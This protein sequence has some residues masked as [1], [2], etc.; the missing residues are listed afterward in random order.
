MRVAW[1]SRV[2]S[3]AGRVRVSVPP[4][5]VR[6]ESRSYVRVTSAAQVTSAVAS[7]HQM[8]IGSDSDGSRLTTSFAPRGF[9]LA[10]IFEAPRVLTEEHTVEMIARLEE[11]GWPPWITSGG[12]AERAVACTHCELRLAPTWVRNGVCLGCEHKVRQWERAVTS[13]VTWTSHLPLRHP[14][15]A[16]RCADRG[17]PVT[18]IVASRATSTVASTV[19]STPHIVLLHLPSHIYGASATTSTDASPLHRPLRPGAPV[20]EMPVWTQV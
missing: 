8:F 20:G 4:L 18:S 10:R 12:S 7:V 13:T 6:S 19:I 17:V 11:R 2:G 3:R 16:S 9:D 15:V 1:G 5:L 14:L